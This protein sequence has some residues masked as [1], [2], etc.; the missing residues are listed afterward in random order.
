MPWLYI[1]IFLLISTGLLSLFGVHVTD[2]LTIF[3]KSKNVTLSGEL[4]VVVGI[5]VKFM[6]YGGSSL[7]DFT[8]LLCIAVRLDASTRKFGLNKF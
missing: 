3:S 8:I 2:L 7:I 4:K 5:P 1:I 6:S